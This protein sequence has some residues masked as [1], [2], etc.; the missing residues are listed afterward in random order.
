M[1]ES[2]RGGGGYIR[3]VRVVEQPGQHLLYLI[4]ERIGD[5]LSEESCVRL[6]SQL[7]EQRLITA[8]EGRLMCAA[9]GSQA[10]S[11]PDGMKDAIRARTM[12]S[13]LTTIARMNRTEISQEPAR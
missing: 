13:M 6:I 8:D 1:I 12:K 11:I 7:C 9:V 2:R 4:N 10:L 5:A 3:I